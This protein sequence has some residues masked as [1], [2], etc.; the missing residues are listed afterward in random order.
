M[1]HPIEQRESERDLTSWNVERAKIKAERDLM[2]SCSDERAVFLAELIAEY[3]RLSVPCDTVLGRY[4]DEM[5]RMMKAT[6][7]QCGRTDLS[8]SGYIDREPE[9]IG[10]TKNK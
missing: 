4:R 9:T 1:K 8:T 10:N 3:N 6:Y 7:I 5:V 2:T